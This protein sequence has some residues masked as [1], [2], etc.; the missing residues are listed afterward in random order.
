M[1]RVLIA[2]L[3]CSFPLAAYSG[4][5]GFDLKGTALT[6]AYFHI[7]DIDG[8]SEAM[9]IVS[10]PGLGR[11]KLA[12]NQTTPEGKKAFEDQKALEAKVRVFKY[13]EECQPD[14][15]KEGK[16]I[17]FSCHDNGKSPLAGSVYRSRAN[18]NL[19]END[20]CAHHYRCI[21]GCG[22]EIPS[23]FEEGGYCG[24]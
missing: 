10:P 12:E 4:S 22:K 24:D 23:E 19:K 17:G 5:V 6:G 18:L 16:R 7:S 2:L 20:S 8:T 21:K 15:D 9:I 13:M 1:V 3:M 11:R 14:Q